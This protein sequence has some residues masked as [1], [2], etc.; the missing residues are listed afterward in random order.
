M[1]RIVKFIRRNRINIVH[2]IFYDSII[3]G[4]LCAIIGRAKNI[5]SWRR[6]LGFW[7]TG[8]RLIF[9]KIMN[10][11]ADKILTNSQ[12]VK[13]YVQLVEGVKD[14]K[15]CVLYNGLDNMQIQGISPVSLKQLSS[16]IRPGTKIVGLVANFNRQVKRVD[17]FLEASAIVSKYFP[18]CAFVIVGGGK[19]KSR[20]IGHAKELNIINKVFFVGHQKNAISYIKK[21]DIGVLTSDSEGFSN[22]LIEYM[23]C[24]I[25]IVS[26]AT[27]SG[28]EL[29]SG[30]D[31]G[32]LTPV[33]DKFA[34]ADAICSLLKDP[35]KCWR[36]GTN[37][38]S[39]IERTFAWENRIKE[40]ET[41]FRSL[42]K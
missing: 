16:D 40:Y 4:T 2:L 12:S 35:E 7:Y 30:I 34:L 18:N 31:V 8:I 36:L 11:F 41:F 17:L 1:L 42:A 23:A 20:L 21:F 25:P 6:D 22:V 24:G 19:L 14:R 5:V 33:G 39:H 15:L 3:I 10:I 38:K 37:A 9:L 29:F 26:T 32:I 27:E 13:N 28:I